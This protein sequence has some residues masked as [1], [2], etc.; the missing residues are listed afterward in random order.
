MDED[1]RRWLDEDDLELAAFRH[2]VIA[3][4]VEAEQGE[5]TAAARRAAGF[6]Y[7]GPGGRL[8]RPSVRTIWRWVAAYRQG[9]LAGLCRKLRKDRGALRAFAPALLE[10]AL[11]LRREGKKEKRSTRTILDILRRERDPALQPEPLWIA[12][13]TLDRHFSRLGASRRQLHVLGQKPFTRIETTAPFELVVIDFHHGPYV[14]VGHRDQVRRALLCAFIDHFS[15]YVPEGRYY[16]HEDYAALRF[17][18]R[19]L[20]CGYGLPRKLYADL[21]P[22]F[23]SRRFHCACDLL[24]IRLVHSRPYAAEARGVIER[25]NGTVKDQFESEVRER[26][27]LLSLEE[28]N[29]YFQAWLSERYHRDIHSETGQAP[30]DRFRE[31]AVLRAAPEPA[32][33]DEL[34]RLYKRCTV[35]RKW[36]TVEIQGQ[37]YSVD[38]SLRR[39]RVGVLY[40]PFAPE[41]VLIT[42]DRRVVQ[43]AF[44]QKAGER[45]PQPTSGPT[46]P[47]TDYLALL[48]RDHERRSQAE[49]AALRLAPAPRVLE[50]PLADLI[51]LLESCRGARLIDEERNT[52][53][54]FWRKMRPIPRDAA[55]DAIR[56]ALRRQGG[57]LHLSVYL[58]AL[59]AHLV[60]MRTEKGPRS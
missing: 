16:L 7:L 23:Q 6:E 26:E 5:I 58:D 30:L 41:Y 56:T 34:L 37:R 20:L 13:S 24:D 32:L 47:R 14:R 12:R 38:P 51:G 49:L 22:A 1:H 10:R 43:R 29:A 2:R 3:E 42:L 48:R 28:L 54:A 27:E 55:T 9:G 35:H 40:D 8:Y 45:F 59:H 44:P 19:C 15:R 18:L 4:I 39:R 17:G 57:N 50:L 46:S 60:R 25:F 52:A 53:S 21:G 11:R 36:A 33:L 31:H